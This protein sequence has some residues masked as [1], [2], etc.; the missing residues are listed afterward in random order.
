MKG[1]MRIMSVESGDKEMQ[2]D[3][4]VLETVDAAA[5]RF[6]ELLLTG[7]MGF[8]TSESPARRIKEFEPQVGRIVVTLPMVGG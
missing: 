3:T 2:W 1:A 4:E 7:H 8:V 6:A 5:A